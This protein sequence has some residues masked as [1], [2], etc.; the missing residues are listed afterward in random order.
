MVPGQHEKR[1][2]LPQRNHHIRDIN[3]STSGF[4]SVEVGN[5][6]MDCSD[7][8]HLEYRRASE[9]YYGNTEFSFIQI[10]MSGLRWRKRA[11]I[12]ILCCIM[13]LLLMLM[14]FYMPFIPNMQTRHS[15]YH[16]YYRLNTKFIYMHSSTEF[17]KL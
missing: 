11:L 15:K 12:R 13:I 10:M 14:S 7:E 4:E 3:N 9:Q 17:Q 16:I 5:S 1:F 6:E 2:L 8:Y